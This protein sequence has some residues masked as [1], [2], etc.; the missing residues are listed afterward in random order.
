M[1]N[2]RLFCLYGIWIDPSVDSVEGFCKDLQWGLGLFP[3]ITTFLEIHIDGRFAVCL[4]LLPQKFIHT[5]LTVVKTL[6]WPLERLKL[7]LSGGLFG[8]L[9]IMFRI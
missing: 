7:L 6:Q 2:T 1:K 5:V 4:R 3:G 9:E 8:T